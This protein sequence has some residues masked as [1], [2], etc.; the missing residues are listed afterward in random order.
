MTH[1][2]DLFQEINDDLNGDIFKPHACEKAEVDSGLLAE[3]I[4]NL[5]FPKSRYRFD[6]IGVELLGSIYETISR[7]HDKRH[8]AARKGRGEAGSQKS[9]RRLL[10][11]K[12]IVEYIVKN[13]VGKIIEGKTPKQIEKIKILILPAGRAHFC[14]A[15]I[16]ILWII[17]SSIIGNIRK[18]RRHC[19]FFLTGRFA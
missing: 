11:A 10:Y 15:L 9:R 16:N 19:S 2:V 7:K 4:E 18:R 6:A 12:Y 1:L 5:Y 14:S 13:T 17:I 8:A 3:I